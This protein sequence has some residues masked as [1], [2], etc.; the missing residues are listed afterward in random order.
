M[1]LNGGMWTY[2]GT[3]TR[4]GLNSLANPGTLSNINGGTGLW[5]AVK[6]P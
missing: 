3:K 4:A 6:L 2:L 5:Y 1:D